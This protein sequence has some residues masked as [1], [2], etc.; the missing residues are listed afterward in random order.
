MEDLKGKD[1]VNFIAEGVSTYVKDHIRDKII[2]EMV[3]DFEARISE[4]VDDK[5]SEMV[6]E[7]YHQDNQIEMRRELLLLIEWS[8]GEAEY[9][10]KY[11][12][13]S[14]MVPK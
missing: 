2:A 4:V 12:M 1:I 7:S 14:E 5:L 9:K 11:E 3:A 13:K 8:K 6:F 10:R